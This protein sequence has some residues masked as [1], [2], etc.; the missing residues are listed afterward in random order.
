MSD[1]ITAGRQMDTTLP[2]DRLTPAELAELHRLLA[3][4][5]ALQERLMVADQQLELLIVAVRDARG[6]QG[7]I[8][9]DPQQGHIR[10]PDDKD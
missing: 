2:A 10:T 1:W 8:Q 9:V 7:R 5:R 3:A 4:R 6:L